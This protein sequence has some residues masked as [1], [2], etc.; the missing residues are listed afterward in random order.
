MH[1]NPEEAATIFIVDDDVGMLRLIQKGLK[2]EGYATAAASSGQEAIEWLCRNRADLMLL[3]LKLQDIEGKE[4]IKHLDVIGRTIPFIIITGQGDERVAVEMMKQGAMDYLVKDIQFLDF[5]PTVVEHALRQIEQQR[6]LVTAE[7]ELR[8]FEKRFSTVFRVSPVAISISRIE[9]G[10][11]VEVNDAWL[12]TLGYAQEEVIGKTSVDL[13]F[14]AS[15]QERENMLAELKS[16]GELRDLELQFARKDGSKGW[17]LLSSEIIEFGGGKYILGLGMD[18]TERKRNEARLRQQA[19]MLDLSHDAILMWHGKGII[20]SWNKGATELYGY[21]PEE[22][23]GQVSHTLLKTVFPVPWAEIEGKLKVKS[24]WEGEFNHTT[25]GGREV[26]VSSRLQRV[27]GS[28]EELCI[29]E[30]NRDITDRKR[31]EGVLR[32][33]IEHAPAG[34]AMFDR[35]MR[36]LAASN[37][38]RQD[39]GLGDNIVGRSHYELF[40][41]LPERWKAAHERALTGEVLRK[42]QDPY[43]RDG[44]TQWLKWEVRPWYNEKGEVGGILIAAE[45]VTGR[46]EAEQALQSSEQRLRKEYAFNS[47]LLRTTRAL[48]VGINPKAQVIH[49]NKAFEDT[50]GY[51]SQDIQ[52]KNFL[53]EL[54][55]PEE[56]ET[57]KQVFHALLTEK[58]PSNYV[59]FICCRDRS[60]RLI[61]WSNDVLLDEQGNVELVIGTGI[62]VTE[63]KRL[64]REVVEASDQEQRRIG[65]DLHDGLGQHLTALELFSHGLLQELKRQAPGLVPRFQELGAQLRQ[66]VREARALSHGLSPVSAYPEG[67]MNAL[68]QLAA[69]TEALTNISC[70][71]ECD[72]P[73]LLNDLNVATH[74]FRISQEAINNALKH[75][76]PRNIVV[77]LRDGADR[78]ELTVEDDG[79]GFS[80]SGKKGKGMGLAVMKHRAEMIGA[81]LEIAS[82]PRKG[83]QIICTL[84]KQA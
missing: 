28:G 12:K 57:V 36:Y 3:D 20:D 52:G 13:R 17:L 71:V 70:R 54:L 46:V 25:K 21:E 1:P 62:D 60:R 72:P 73:M 55:V 41:D 39:Y 37:L 53:D 79:R 2:R 74:L 80:A 23:I 6:R 14:W 51:S 26:I 5:V 77:R 82:S 4:L 75:G 9:T 47:A 49:F 19:Q 24:F 61:S 15:I 32:L 63:Q 65:R 18:I 45:N 27:P 50:T 30:S 44:K 8:N 48:I 29:L 16:K 81:T 43:I 42:E 69:K 7:E 38:W 83:T 67:L 66:T 56:V 40:P 11:F 59:N 10:E 78:W 84:R 58:R 35:E 68:T 34:V 76:K 64:E 31:A 33:F 22:A